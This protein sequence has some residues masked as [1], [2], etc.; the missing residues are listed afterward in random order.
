MFD[1]FV[2]NL[3]MANAFANG[4]ELFSGGRRHSHFL[5]PYLVDGHC[6]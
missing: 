1:F 2:T 5:I 3:R 6:L 4:R